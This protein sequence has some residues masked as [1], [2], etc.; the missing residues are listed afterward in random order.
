MQ[1]FPFPAGPVLSVDLGH[2]IAGVKVAIAAVAV[3]AAP[4]GGRDGAAVGGVGGVALL[5]EFDALHSGDGERQMGPRPV[6]AL[7]QTEVVG[8][9]LPQVVLLLPFALQSV[10][11]L[12]QL[13][14]GNVLQT[15]RI[16]QLAVEKN[17]FLLQ[18][19]NFVL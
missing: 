16:V 10:Q 17:G 6:H 7:A 11:G 19:F 13:T 18:N 8:Q 9:L 5:V 14:L 12:L 15:Q 3:L 1:V 2:P 4:V